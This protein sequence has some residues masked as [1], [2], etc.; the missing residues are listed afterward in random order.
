MSPFTDE[1]ILVTGAGSGLGRLLSLRMVEAGAVVAGIDRGPDGLAAAA[2]EAPAD[3]FAWA[4]ADVTD[5]GALFAAVEQLESKV[6]PFDRL[7]A[8]AGVGRA[9]PATEFSSAEFEDIVRVNLFGVANSV[10][11][12]LP[13]MIARGKGHLVALSSLASFRGMPKMAAYCASK[14]GV[15]ALFDSLS[16][17]LKHTGVRM[18]TV[19]P[20]W[21]RT[22][23]TASL[24]DK[25]PNLLEPE[26]AVQRILD[27]VRKQK[28]FVAFPFPLAML[29]RIMRWLPPAV[30]D[31]MLARQFKADASKLGQ[32]TADP[33]R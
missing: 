3:R 27:A 29:V 9:T 30:S 33:K 11:A 16:V 21:I 14:T 13:G 2:S 10:E 18:T 31:R 19:C 8:C 6:G 17:E 12:V 20:G 24:G 4:V 23:M 25:L 1:R 5:R 28:R 7:I 15:N 32:P 22:P 26:D